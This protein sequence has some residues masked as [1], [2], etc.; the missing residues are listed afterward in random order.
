MTKRVAIY[1]RVST[2]EQTTANQRLDLEAWA[3]CQG[4]GLALPDSLGFNGDG[5]ADGP[6]PVS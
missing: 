2:G 4:I 3:A 5:L 1:L 6:G